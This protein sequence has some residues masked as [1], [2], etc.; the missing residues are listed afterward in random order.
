MNKARGF[1]DV[2]GEVGGEGDDVVIGG[3]LDLVDALDGEAWRATLICSSASCG[4]VPISAWTSQTA[5]ST[6]SHF[7]NL[8]CSDQSAPISGNV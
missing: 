2:F 1:A 6:S 5:I 3:L 7:W 4:I 8:F